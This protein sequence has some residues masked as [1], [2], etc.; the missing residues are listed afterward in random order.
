LT[1]AASIRE[2]LKLYEKHG[3]TLRRVLLSKDSRAQLADELGEL[4]GAAAIEDFARDGAW[5]SRASG[6]DKEAWELR[7]FGDAPFALM[8]V[9]GPEQREEEREEARR[10][11]EE[12]MLETDPAKMAR[13]AEEE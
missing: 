8:E 6:K 3:W 4:F 13:T 11:V 2:A 1:D 7:L 10:A 12:R 9:F 5:F